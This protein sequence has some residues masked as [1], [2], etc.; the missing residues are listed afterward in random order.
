MALTLD[1]VVALVRE[2]TSRADFETTAIDAEQ[3]DAETVRLNVRCVHVGQLTRP[4]DAPLFALQHLVRLAVKRRS[5]DEL[6][7]VVLDADSYRTE[8]EESIAS[9]ARDVAARVRETGIAYEFPPML[10]YKRR[11]IH[12][13][14]LEPGYADLNVYSVGEGLRRRVRVEPRTDAPSS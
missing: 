5:P 4:S 14:F 2:F 13:L 1:D 11:A 8:Q 12:T 7:H 9:I 10:S 3:V 6:P